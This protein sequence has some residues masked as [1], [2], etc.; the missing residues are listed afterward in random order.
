MMTRGQQSNYKTG[1]NIV[2]D[3]TV[4]KSERGGKRET[5]REKRLKRLGIDA[6]Q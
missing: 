3:S 6:V 2:S 5:I 1:P 4:L